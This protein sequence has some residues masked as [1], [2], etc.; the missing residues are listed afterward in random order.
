MAAL[1]KDRSTPARSGEHVS[2]PVKAGVK[3]FAGAI[4]VLDADGWAKPGVPGTGLKVRGRA[5]RQVDNT[6]GANG[7][8]FV[9]SN[10]KN[11]FRFENLATDLVDRT[12]IGA[13]CFIVDDQTVAATNGGNPATRSVA[14]KVVDVDD[15]GVWVTFA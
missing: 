3:I 4:V 14:G 1:T 9:M 2:D 8:A 13:D 7:D 10:R 15:S 5:E 12:M 11:V 6:L